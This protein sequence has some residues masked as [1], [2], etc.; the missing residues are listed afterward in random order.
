MDQLIQLSL[1]LYI[2]TVIESNIYTR[3]RIHIQIT[4]LKYILCTITIT[5]TRV[6]KIFYWFEKENQNQRL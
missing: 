1:T 6:T 2:F 3:A 4:E 5:I